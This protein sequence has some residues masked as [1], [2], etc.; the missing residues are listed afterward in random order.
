MAKSADRD[1]PY[2]CGV[3]SEDEGVLTVIRVDLYAGGVREQPLADL[4][5]GMPTLGAL[6]RLNYPPE[7]AREE[8][9]IEEPIEEPE[10]I[11]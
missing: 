7:S 1:T 2:Y 4:T 8:V 10:L 6:W 11:V 5:D 3:L 9:R